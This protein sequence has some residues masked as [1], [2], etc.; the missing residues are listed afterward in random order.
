MGRNNINQ[1]QFYNSQEMKKNHKEYRNNGYREQPLFM[2]ERECP[3]RKKERAPT[4]GGTS[5]IRMETLWALH[6]A[7][8][9]KGKQNLKG[10]N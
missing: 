3:K 1:E 2:T 6:S 9:R 7:V 8:K 4:A 10:R 5:S